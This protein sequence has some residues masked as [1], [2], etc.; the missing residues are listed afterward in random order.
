MLTRHVALV[1]QSN[2]VD[3]TL[4]SSIA[5]AV[6]KQV[7]RDFSPIWNIDATVSFFPTL[8]N[9]PAGY[10]PI[11]ILDQLND[12]NA[13]GY[14]TDQNGQPYA[15]VLSEGQVSVD[16]SHECLEMLVDPFGNRTVASNSIKPGQ[17]RVEYLVEVCDPCEAT[18]L[19]YSVNGLPVSDFYTPHF[20]DPVSA[21]GVRYSFTGAVTKPR[22]L[23][24][25]G[26]ISWLNPLDRHMYQA[27]YF[28]SKITFKDLGT[29][30]SNKSLREWVDGETAKEIAKHYGSKFRAGKCGVARPHSE[31]S[32]AWAKAFRKHLKF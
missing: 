9:V 4:T 32:E 10:W 27:F 7:T 8:N 21:P 22:Q 20:F 12:P 26:Y 29:P 24:K 16:V 19:A 11:V 14:H 1:S 28:G 30:T 3:A 25:Q 31:A 23:L 18:D 13:G 2:A 5:A 15:L 6:Q 17:G